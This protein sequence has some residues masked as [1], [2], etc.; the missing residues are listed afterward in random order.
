MTVMDD[1]NIMIYTALC[2]AQAAYV[3]HFNHSVTHF[4]LF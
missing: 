2:V 3:Q 4:V 1:V